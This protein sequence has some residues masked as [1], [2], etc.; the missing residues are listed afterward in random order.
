[1]KIEFEDKSYVEI[2]KSKNPNKV[3]ITIVARDAARVDSIIASSVEVS[4]EQF[5]QLINLEQ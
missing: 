1:M 5:T 3:M 4:A 2:T